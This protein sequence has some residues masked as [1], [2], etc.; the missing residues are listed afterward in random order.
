MQRVIFA[1]TDDPLERAGYLWRHARHAM[2]KAT[3]VGEGVEALRSGPLSGKPPLVAEL[4]AFYVRPWKES[5][6]GAHFLKKQGLNL[7]ERAQFAGSQASP[8]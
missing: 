3:N 6:P 1:F 5:D 2:L 4:S 8:S 7:G